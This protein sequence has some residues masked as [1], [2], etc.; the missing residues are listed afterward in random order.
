MPDFSQRDTPGYRASLPCTVGYDV[1][2]Y[3]E[4]EKRQET[5]QEDEVSAVR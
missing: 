2:V 4:G 5:F 1:G 3:A